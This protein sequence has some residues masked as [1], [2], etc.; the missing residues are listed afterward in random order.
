MNFSLPLVMSRWLSS[1]LLSLIVVKFAWKGGALLNITF[2]GKTIVC[3]KWNIRI[4]LDGKYKFTEN[5]ENPSEVSFMFATCPIVE[6]SRLPLHK[7]KSEYKLMCCPDHQNCM[8]L[9]EFPAYYDVSK[10]Y[11]VP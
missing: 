11:N 5:P 3:P 8:Y 9:N 7:Q 1:C 4:T 10:G 2:I 6:N